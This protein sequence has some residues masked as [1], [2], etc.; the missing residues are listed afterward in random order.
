M[1]LD[2]VG[3]RPLQ[4]SELAL[5]DRWVLS[6]LAGA[7]DRVHQALVAYNPS[8]ALSAAREFFWGDLCDWYLEA[9]KLRLSLGGILPGLLPGASLATLNCESPLIHSLPTTAETI[10]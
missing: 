8:A 4:V 6:R 9:I 3:F 2:E 1:N 10:V 7:I 5:E